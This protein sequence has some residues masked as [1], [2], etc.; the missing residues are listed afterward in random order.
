VAEV[1]QAAIT[2]KASAILICHNHPSGTIDASPEDVAVTQAIVKAGKL[3]DIQVIDH[4]ILGAGAW[5][6]LREK[7]LGFG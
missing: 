3:L 7:G 4:L 6:S 2:Q 1:F 5:C